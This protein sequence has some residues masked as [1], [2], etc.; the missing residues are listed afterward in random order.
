MMEWWKCGCRK[1]LDG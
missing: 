1:W